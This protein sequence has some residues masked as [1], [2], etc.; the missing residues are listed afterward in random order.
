MMRIEVTDVDN[1]DPEKQ[2]NG[3][4]E[5]VTHRRDC[6]LQDQVSPAVCSVA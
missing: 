1:R 2:G 5:A 3:G 6:P 4:E